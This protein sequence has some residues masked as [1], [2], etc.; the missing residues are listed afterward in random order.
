[1]GWWK[2]RRRRKVRETDRK[3]GRQAEGWNHVRGNNGWLIRERGILYE[4]DKT[5]KT[6]RRRLMGQKERNQRKT[7]SK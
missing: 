6:E 1:M 7:V 3:T 2:G 5:G 4:S